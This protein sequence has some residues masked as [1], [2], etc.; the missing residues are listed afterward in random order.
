MPGGFVFR[1]QNMIKLTSDFIKEIEEI[2]NAGKTAEIS[3][4]NGKIV[5]WAV[6]SKK[7]TEQPIA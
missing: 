6:N 2:L 7:K 5:L 3:I 1:L 4:R